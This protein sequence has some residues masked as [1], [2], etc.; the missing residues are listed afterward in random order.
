[1]GHTLTHLLMFFLS[2]AL[3]GLR[4]FKIKDK[5]RGTGAQEVPRTLPNLQGRGFWECGEGGFTALFYL[6][7]TAHPGQKRENSMLHSRLISFA[8]IQ[9]FESLSTLIQLLIY[10]KHLFTA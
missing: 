10:F 1:M 5:V 7:S 4:K 8:D 2:L 3:K 6:H 9:E